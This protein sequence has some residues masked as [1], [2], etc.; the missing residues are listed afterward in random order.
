MRGGI[1]LTNDAT[2][3]LSYDPAILDDDRA[4]RLIAPLLG[5][6]AHLKGAPHEAIFVGL[7]G[8]DDLALPIADST[9]CG[10]GQPK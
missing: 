10:P 3:S 1:P 2:D 4:V 5:G 8:L 6:A 9:A 7:C